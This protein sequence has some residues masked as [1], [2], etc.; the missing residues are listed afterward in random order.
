MAALVEGLGDKLAP[1][2]GQLENALNQLRMA[3]VQ[4]S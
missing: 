2:Q 4:L 3:F 1:Y